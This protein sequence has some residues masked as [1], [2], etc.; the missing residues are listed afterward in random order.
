MTKGRYYKPVIS[1][2]SRPL[3]GEEIP[4]VVNF[5]LY[6]V[7]IPILGMA[8]M[9]KKRVNRSNEG[10]VSKRQKINPDAARSE[11]V[12]LDQLQWKD[13]PFPE[14]FDDAE[15]FLGLEEISDVEVSRDEKVG[16][17]AYKIASKKVDKPAIGNK[18][19]VTKGDRLP[20]ATPSIQDDSEDDWEGFAESPQETQKL[21]NNID[22][23]STRKKKSKIPPRVSEDGRQNRS[24]EGARQGQFESLR[25]LEE[26]DGDVS[27]WEE[28][29]LSEETMAALARMNFWRPT[30]V[31]RAAIPEIRNGH[32]V[33]GKASTGSGKTLAFGIPIFEF[34]LQNNRSRA[35]TN[36]A[37]VK[38]E[39]RSPIALI[40][41]P[42]RE[43]AHQ[44]SDHLSDLCGMADGPAIATL[45]GGL[46]V[47][48]QQRLLTRADIIIGTPGRIWEL[49]SG[50]AELSKKLQTIE[51]LVL[52]EA[53]R[54]LSEGHFKELT[55]ILNALDRSIGD[56]GAEG[57]DES[58][59]RSRTRRQNLV[60]S[61]TFQKDLQ[62]KLAGRSKQSGNELM[63]QSESMEYLLK[64]ID[65]REEK[66]KFIDIN[67]ISQMAEN[68][69][70]GIVEC[71]G[72]EKVENSEE[73]YSSCAKI[74]QR[75]P[76]SIHYS[77]ITQGLVY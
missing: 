29:N 14:R 73:C 31:Q 6:F 38:D 5:T 74:L 20:V 55:E 76:T 52:D 33:I 56:G 50:D 71:A 66:P 37:S 24:A 70:E 21:M 54:L 35:N 63:S 34:H 42:T 9:T 4:N 43:L 67:P 8:P 19:A 61:A 65:F 47:H 48:K 45:T 51:F 40:I 30:P 49:M 39:S 46:S 12:S 15:G 41:S 53:D 60:F 2:A 32:D 17:V 23:I 10:H 22:P 57:V 77:S 3:P 44:L 25:D 69:T 64:K 16:R 75:I 26:Y 18:S 59:S 13:V 58:E 1:G 7:S 36:R 11:T 27:K 68:L 28:L 62:Q 72:L